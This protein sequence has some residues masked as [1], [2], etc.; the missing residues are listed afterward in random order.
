M[1]EQIVGWVLLAALMATV[2]L[3]TVVLQAFRSTSNQLLAVASNEFHE[4]SMSL[5][6]SADELPEGVLSVL[7]TMNSSAFARGTPWI[8]YKA[9]KEART[10][11]AGSTKATNHH[12][13]FDEFGKLRPELRKL[14]GTVGA[15]WLNILTHRNLFLHFLIANEMTRMQVSSGSVSKGQDNES[16]F[17]SLIPALR[18]V[19]C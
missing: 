17:K 14:F 8:L 2:A 9:L 11:R 12:S 18:H 13:D 4:A 7:G 3:L 1:I 15:S 10:G 19:D 16:S 5:L 6:E